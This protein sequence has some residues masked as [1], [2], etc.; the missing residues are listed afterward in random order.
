MDISLQLPVLMLYC[1]MWVTQIYSLYDV[2][3]FSASMQSV[4]RGAKIP[5]APLE[6]GFCTVGGSSICERVQVACVTSI[7]CSC[8]LH[9]TLYCNSKYRTFVRSDLTVTYI[10]LPAGAWGPFVY[11]VGWDDSTVQYEGGPQK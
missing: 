6:E 9:A 11:L 10:L 3:F 7:T 5:C 2:N 1:F 8:V 4:D